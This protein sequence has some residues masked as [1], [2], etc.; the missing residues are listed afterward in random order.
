[1]PPPQG[2]PVPLTWEQFR[3]K[4]ASNDRRFAGNDIA[5]D[6]KTVGTIA[7]NTL[8]AT[9]FLVPVSQKFD[10]ITINVTTVGAG[11]SARCG[12]YKDNGSIYPGVLYFDSGVIDT[13]AGTVK[14]TT[15]TAGLQ[16]FPPGLYWLAYVCSATAPAIRC[17]NMQQCYP[18]MGTGSGAGNVAPAVGYTVAFTFAALPD[19]FTGSATYITGAP[20]PTITLRAV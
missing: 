16:Q 5:S 17:Q 18:L 7:A 3:I 2:Y 11:S 15:I 1:M 10:T 6:S 19:P 9:P 12:V 14:D 8:V 13:S 20:V 4:G